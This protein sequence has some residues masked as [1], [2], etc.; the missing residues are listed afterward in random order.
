MAILMAAAVASGPADPLGPAS[1]A[2]GGGVTKCASGSLNPKNTKPMPIPA[3]NI[4]A[5]HETVRNSGC[6]PSRPS[7]IRPKRLN[8]RYRMKATK[9]LADRTKNQPTLVMSQLSARAVKLPNDRVASAPQS[10]SA[11]MVAATLPNTTQSVFPFCFAA[12]I[13]LV[14][15]SKLTTTD[16]NNC[17]EHRQTLYRV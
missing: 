15:E 14:A 11:M 6:S 4:I 5:I 1:A 16:A 12:D 7:G 9:P 10:T 13:G 17:V 2:P 8:A 3:L